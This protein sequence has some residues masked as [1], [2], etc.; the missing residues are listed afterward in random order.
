MVRATSA[1]CLRVDLARLEPLLERLG[2][3]VDEHDLVGLVEDAVG[4][5]LADADAGDLEDRVVE[6]LEMLHV[7]R[8]DD[9]DPRLEDLVDVL[10]ALLVARAGRVRV[11]ELVDEGELGCALEHG[12]DVH[13]P[14]HQ[15]A[16]RH[17]HSRHEL[18]TLGERGGLGPVVR[19]E[20]ADHDVAPLGVRLPALLQHPIGLADAGG[21]AEQDAVAAAHDVNRQR[22]AGESTDRS[23]RPAHALRPEEVVHD[24]VDQ[25]DPDERE[26]HAAETVDQQVPAQERRRADGAVA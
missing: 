5:G 10:V 11:R 21:H 24:Q 12:V 25:L 4:E 18:E 19:L 17:R 1:R 26:D 23:S 15:A 13:L 7:H 6:A 16:V 9:V 20:I 2:R 22:T 14:E 8:G 3:E